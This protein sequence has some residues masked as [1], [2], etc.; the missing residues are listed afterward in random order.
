[1]V[2]SGELEK[3][4]W[5]MFLKQQETRLTVTADERIMVM[6]HPRRRQMVTLEREDRYLI[7]TTVVDQAV[8]SEVLPAALTF[9]GQQKIPLY[10]LSLRRDAYFVLARTGVWPATDS[11]Q[12][13]Y[14]LT[15]GLA[16]TAVALSLEL[17]R[18]LFRLLS[19]PE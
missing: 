17:E 16:E 11:E 19:S 7:A 6:L 3:H 9:M 13:L 8:T 4:I 15:I 14:D 5:Q 18:C 12:E 1:M 2:F 10:A